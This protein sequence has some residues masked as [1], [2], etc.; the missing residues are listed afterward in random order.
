MAVGL[1]PLLEWRGSKK[2]RYWTIYKTDVYETSRLRLKKTQLT[3]QIE[4][5]NQQIAELDQRAA[6]EDESQQLKKAESLL[7]RFATQNMSRIECQQQIQMYLF[8]KGDHQRNVE[9]SSV[10]S[11]PFVSEIFSKYEI[12]NECSSW[13]ESSGASDT[14]NKQAI[15][16]AAR[17]IENNGLILNIHS[18]DLQ[19]SK[20]SND[21]EVNELG[22][23]SN[24]VE[25]PKRAMNTAQSKRTKNVANGS[26]LVE[27]GKT[28]KDNASQKNASNLHSSV[29]EIA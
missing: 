1:H 7:N 29:G 20:D 3:Q 16:D 15:E 19:E 28:V 9:E 14:D 4:T 5:L 17:S 8:D 12:A 13:T 27:L 21:D 26:E 18:L 23:V 10:S 24:I 6:D 2:Q 25:S 11:D 22:Q